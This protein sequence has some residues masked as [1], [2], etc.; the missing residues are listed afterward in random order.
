M[1][2]WRRNDRGPHILEL[3]KKLLLL[4]YDLPR[5]GADG[6]L[7][8]ETL[9]AVSLF[10][11]DHGLGTV[12]MD[13]ADSVPASVR[14][15]I[16]AAVAERDAGVGVPALLDLRTAHNGDLQKAI[17]PWR[18][19]TGI[20]L[21]QTAVVLGETPRRWFS[22]PIHIGIT[23]MG[24]ILILNALDTVTWHANGLNAND[25]GIEIDGYYEGVE[26]NLRTFWRPPT[27]PDRVPMI[28]APVQI[29]AARTAARWICDEVK[30][31]G[32]EITY[33]HA[34]RQSS[35][36]RESDPGSHIWGGVGL[37]AQRELGL[38]DGG[39]EF[40]TGTG[41]R[42]PQEWDPS[43]TGIKYRPG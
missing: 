41:T 24:Q 10:R 29:E 18:Q 21:H 9:I 36:Q 3:Q 42:I 35:G 8:D 33:I 12:E 43:R 30:R 14:A 28:P 40:K 7:G 5:F 4:G 19:V 37:W 34:H 20:T 23:R 1:A 6:W 39:R 22:V 16:D 2:T 15:A 38:S 17:R 13:Y 27:E 11:S 26:G 31:H 25:V 32:G